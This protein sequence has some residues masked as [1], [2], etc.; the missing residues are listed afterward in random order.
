MTMLT[1]P[2]HGSLCA[3]SSPHRTGLL[4]STERPP[5]SLESQAPLPIRGIP[6]AVGSQIQAHPPQVS[7]SHIPPRLPEL[8]GLGNAM[9]SRSGAAAL[10][11]W[12]PH[13]LGTPDPTAGPHSTAG[14]H[15][16]SIKLGYCL[17]FVPSL[18]FLLPTLSP[19]T[20]P[21]LTPDA[22]SHAPKSRWPPP[23]REEPPPDVRGC[24]CG[25]AGGGG[26]GR[27]E[28]CHRVRRPA[29][30]YLRGR[31]T[32]LPGLGGGRWSIFPARG[33]SRWAPRPGQP[34]P[35]PGPGG[36]SRATR[37][38]EPSPAEPRPLPPTAPPRCPA[39]L[40]ATEPRLP[41]ADSAPAP[42]RAL[43]AG[44]LTPGR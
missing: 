12:T 39:A 38:P 26:R 8:P 10:S 41:R 24:S 15:P 9:L 23:V 11:P 20:H 6:P 7:P 18:S 22:H 29:G 40:K 3:G 4:P 32:V 14:N 16:S 34:R 1:L 25:G 37:R 28:G 43:K 13:V 19:S 27:G 21:P 33:H 42:R 44:P 31:R 17:S 35:R 5:K 36:E 2:F 30:A